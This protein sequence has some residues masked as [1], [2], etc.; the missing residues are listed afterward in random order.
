MKPNILSR[1]IW[2]L[3]ILLTASL[4]NGC[5]K[6]TEPE[7][8]EVVTTGSATYITAFSATLTGFAYPTKDMGEVRFGVLVSER[9]SISQDG[10]LDLP[11]NNRDGKNQFKVETDQLKPDTKYYFKAYLYDG[12]TYHYGK[13]VP[14][15]TAAFV[16]SVVTQDETDVTAQSVTFHAKLSTDKE[17]VSKLEVGFQYAVSEADVTSGKGSFIQGMKGANDT[18]SAAVEGLKPGTTYYYRAAATYGQYQAFG[19]VRSFTTGSEVAPPQPDAIITVN[20]TDIGPFAVTLAGEAH[21]DPEMSLGILLSDQA[22]PDKDNSKDFSVQK[23]D[24]QG[25]FQ[26][27]ADKLTPETKYYYRA[28]VL[29]D[30]NYYFGSIRSFETPAG[31]SVTTGTVV[32]VTH[33]SAVLNGAVTVLADYPSARLRVGFVCSMTEDSIR[34]ETYGGDALPSEDNSLVCELEADGT[35]HGT[36]EGFSP[37][38]Q[39]YYRAYA[40]YE[41]GSY[42]KFGEIRSFNTPKDP[43]AQEVAD[44]MIAYDG[45]VDYTEPDGSVSPLESFRF[46]Y[47]GNNYF[48]I[49]TILTEDISADYYD[50]IKWYFE[51]QAE[52][53]AYQAAN[54]GVPVSELPGV[55]DKNDKSAYFDLLLHGDY[56]AFLIEIT[57]DGAAT[58]NYAKCACVVEE[59]AMTE[60]FSQWLGRWRVSDGHSAFD[61]DISSCEA[62]YLYYVNGWETGS[63]V[64]VQMDGYDDWFFARYNRKDGA[65]CFYGQDIV[66][67]EDVE[68]DSFADEAFAGQYLYKGSYYV[69]VEGIDYRYDIAHTASNAGTITLVPES[70]DL[71]DGTTVTYDTM[72]YFKYVYSKEIW[73]SFNAEGVPFFTG[74]TVTLTAVNPAGAPRAVKAA[75]PHKLSKTR[76]VLHV[77]REKT[78]ARRTPVRAEKRTGRVRSGVRK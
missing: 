20:A 50:D 67:F 52:D 5:N 18:F 45:R 11:A 58:G 2:I 10:S 28:Y 42:C 77:H 44:W 19:E 31:L 57:A 17:N 4:V 37:K 76:E 55:F 13:V 9:E 49:R 32:D 53:L 74:R 72:Q 25:K 12:S 16:V 71:N 27:K 75:V 6:Q 47:T 61:I 40:V 66:S 68:F 60:G 48:F 41:D 43:G 1:S 70:F 22:E 23:P 56:T 64:S 7:Q 54:Q 3:C 29:F 24:G 78:S 73:Y 15:K 59:E 36:I 34:E 51:Q 65:L 26:V 21:P 46:K 35:F 30:G 14:F 63:G 38:T 39:Y 8:K 62:N 69:D 33:H